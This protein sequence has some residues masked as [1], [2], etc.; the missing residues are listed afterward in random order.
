MKK[1]VP[2]LFVIIFLILMQVYMFPFWT[3]DVIYPGGKIELTN[4]ITLPTYYYEAGNWINSQSEEFNLLYLPPQAGTFRYV[5]NNTRYGGSDPLDEYI[6]NKPVIISS[7]EEPDQYGPYNFSWQV[8][9][10]LISSN[11]TGNLFCKMLTIM[12]IKYIILHNDF[13]PIFTPI[14]TE[15]V[16]N[17]LNGQE[18]I[19]LVK[20]FGEVDIFENMLWNESAV[21]ATPNAVL[22][23]ESLDNLT[24]L[25]NFSVGKNIVFQSNQMKSGQL[26]FL[27][28]LHQQNDAPPPQI[29]FEKINPTDYVVHVNST[30][31]TFIVLSEYYDT[32]W[33]AYVNGV[34]V[35]GQNHF[36]ANV[37]TNAWYIDNTGSFTVTIEF[38][39]QRLVY[40]GEAISSATLVLCVLYLSNNKLKALFSHI[41]NKKSKFV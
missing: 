39:P 10:P 40:I 3:G 28:G 25:G 11:V 31:P 23:Q 35:S 22:A 32:G 30:Q 29:T 9:E 17:D 24:E 15:Q 19:S 36:I 38:S 37:Y 33:T 18:G 20:S 14:S 7:W 26:Q 41:K 8:I 16:K 6:F 5:W 27:E 13:D 1:Y 34:Q 21:Y 4:R 12:N 2:V